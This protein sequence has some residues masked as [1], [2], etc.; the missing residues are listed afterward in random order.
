PPLRH[1]LAR[2][3]RVARARVAPLARPARR[4]GA[5]LA[6]HLCDG[7]SARH[8]LR[9]VRDGRR[10]R[11]RLPARLPHCGDG[12]RRRQ[13]DGLLHVAHRLQRL[14]PP[15]RRRRP[16]LRRPR[17]RPPQRRPRHADGRA[18]LPAALQRVQRLPRHRARRAARRLRRRH[19]PR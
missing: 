8:R 2:H 12:H 16:A 4:L 5:R 11:L 7:L 17:P 3:L 1:L 19:G 15:P 6:L 10:L 9:H 13:P 18:L 14:R